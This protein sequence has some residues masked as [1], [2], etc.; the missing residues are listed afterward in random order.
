MTITNKQFLK[1]CALYVKG[2]ITELRFRGKPTVVEA[3]AKTLSA[4]R[5]FYVA[6]QEESFPDAVS[7]LKQKR[8]ASKNLREQTGYTW[9]L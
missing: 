4:S 3:F 2:D 5:K 7:A 1:D 8:A 9:P 6:V